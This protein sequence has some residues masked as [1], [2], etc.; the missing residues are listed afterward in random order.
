VFARSS[1][2]GTVTEEEFEKLR[3]W[4]EALTGDERPE[5]RAAGRAIIL[6]AGEV[7]RLQVQAW[8]ARLGVES[9]ARQAPEPS[10]DPD[11]TLSRQLEPELRD[12]LRSAVAPTGR[13]RRLFATARL[14][15]RRP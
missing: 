6:L 15:T 14:N 3:S 9:T 8:H 13:V 5:V 10:V 4:G 12:R 1:L 11:S 7:E 2:P